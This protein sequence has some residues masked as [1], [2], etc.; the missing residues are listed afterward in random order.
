VQ[1]ADQADESRPADRRP[2]GHPIA[3]RHLIPDGLTAPT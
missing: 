3:R 1:P 2:R